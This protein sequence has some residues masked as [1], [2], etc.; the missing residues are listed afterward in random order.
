MTT[1]DPRTAGTRDAMD[2]L[3]QWTDAFNTSAH[4]AVPLRSAGE[5]GGAQLRLR[6]EPSPGQVSIFHMVAV[7]R[8]GRPVILVN[9]FD[10]PMPDT[11]VRAGLWAS[12]QLGR[13]T[14]QR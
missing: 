5:A 6:Y 12:E 10:G 3:Q 9:R 4:P 13:R 2:I 1:P 11:A 7:Q 8:D 14:D